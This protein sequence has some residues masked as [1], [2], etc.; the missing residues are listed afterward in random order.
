M[1]T[2]KKALTAF[3]GL[4]VLMISGEYVDGIFSIFLVPLDFPEFW[5]M[6]LTGDI[7]LPRGGG[8]NFIGG[9]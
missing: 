5:Q 9:D 8:T 2:C 3:A 7:R 1:E 6:G 4:H